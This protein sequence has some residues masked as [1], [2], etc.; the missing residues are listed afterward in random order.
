[1]AVPGRTFVGPSGR[2]ESHQAVSTDVVRCETVAPFVLV[3]KDDWRGT[4]VISEFKLDG[5]T[6]GGYCHYGDSAWDWDHCR[7][8][9]DDSYDC[10]RQTRIQPPAPLSR[11]HKSHLISGSCPTPSRLPRACAESERVRNF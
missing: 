9:A 1:M 3:Q 10:A 5:R 11:P 6:P 2:A 4:L 7:V 8:P